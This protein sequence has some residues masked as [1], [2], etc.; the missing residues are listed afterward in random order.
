MHEPDLFADRAKRLFQFLSRAQQLKTP[1]V[2]TTDRYLRDGAVHWLHAIPV[3]PAVS[4][5]GRDTD[6][7]DDGFV[8]SC[9]RVD[10][11]RAARAS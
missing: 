11:V 5:A 7:A 1:S 3:H 8:L 9:R 2:P 6:A 4:L 10:K